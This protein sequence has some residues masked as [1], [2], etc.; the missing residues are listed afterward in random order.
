MPIRHPIPDVSE[1]VIKSKSVRRFLSHFVR[2][3]AAVAVVP[4]YEIELAVVEF[5]NR[6]PA[7]FDP[8]GLPAT[9]LVIKLR[10][11]L[12]FT[13]APRILTSIPACT[14]TFMDCR[15]YDIVTCSSWF[16]MI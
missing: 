5:P 10:Q 13:S 15:L 2:P 12:I 1:H 7:A 16:C 11:E 3:A 14:S 8:A 9:T 4:G 6:Q